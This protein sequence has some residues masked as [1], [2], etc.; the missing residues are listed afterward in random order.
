MENKIRPN[1][2]LISITYTNE[3]YPGSTIIEETSKVYSDDDTITEYEN[4]E[5]N[6]KGIC[7]EFV[8]Y[9]ELINCM[10]RVFNKEGNDID[11]FGYRKEHRAK[12]WLYSTI[13]KTLTKREL[14]DG[15]IR[16][17]VES[18]E[19]NEYECFYIFEDARDYILETT[20][21]IISIK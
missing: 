3:G 13:D 4:F 6:G 21:H 15:E 8:N 18:L 19:T 17:F 10:R 5:F 11:D 2:L 20:G 9:D 7:E 16:W 12:E 14:S 1:E